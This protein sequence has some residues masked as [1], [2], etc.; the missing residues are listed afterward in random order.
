MG[1]TA[2]FINELIK[3]AAKS[4]VSLAVREAHNPTAARYLPNLRARINAAKKQGRPLLGVIRSKIT[5]G[6]RN[7]G[8][9]HNVGN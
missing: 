3:I 1:I 8:Y 2:A 6:A 5:G 9:I 4:P 7:A